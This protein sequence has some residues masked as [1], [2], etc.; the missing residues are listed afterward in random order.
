MTTTDD[1]RWARL[2]ASFRGSKWF[3]IAL[4]A[5]VSVWIGWNVCPFL[6]HFDDAEFGRL[7]LFLSTEASLSVALL[8]IANERQDAKQREHLEHL[9]AIVEH[10][11]VEQH[12]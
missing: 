9:L 5:V 6:P 11:N 7:N 2:Y 10:L 8:I 3:L 4:F 1:A 12:S